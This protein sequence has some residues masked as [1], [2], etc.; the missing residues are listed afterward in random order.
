MR[1]GVI[2]YITLSPD[3][4]AAPSE[5]QRGTLKMKMADSVGGDYRGNQHIE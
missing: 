4:E 2:F 1:A 3:F 5:K